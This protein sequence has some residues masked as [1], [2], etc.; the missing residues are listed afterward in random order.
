M[1]D[2]LALFL[3]GQRHPKIQGDLHRLEDGSIYDGNFDLM[4]MGEMQTEFI[5]E[6]PQYR[7][8]PLVQKAIA[9]ME[10]I[11]TAVLQAES[12]PLNAAH[13]L[14]RD[15]LIQLHRFLQC[16]QTLS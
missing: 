6:I 12:N 16:F 14:C 7:D 15:F 2:R 11:D 9:D 4:V 10:K 8:S 5:N 13:P 3:S 1:P